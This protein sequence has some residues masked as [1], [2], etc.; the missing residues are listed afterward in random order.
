MLRKGGLGRY[1]ME[2]GWGVISRRGKALTLRQYR[3]LGLGRL[4]GL[5]L[6]HQLQRRRVCRWR[7]M[8]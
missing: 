6:R 8:S 5:A 1:L 4:Q 3:R 2:S 7:V